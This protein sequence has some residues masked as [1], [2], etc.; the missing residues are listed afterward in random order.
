M[1]SRLE[2]RANN[3]RVESSNLSMAKLLLQNR[4]SN[5]CRKER[6]G[7]GHCKNARKTME[8]QIEL[9]KTVVELARLD[10][11][12]NITKAEI[13][14]RPEREGSVRKQHSSFATV[15]KRKPS[16]SSPSVNNKNIEH[17]N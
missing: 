4:S 7:V 14:R 1:L 8:T 6:Q 15:Q 9:T 13:L 12:A 10:H 17:L 11:R 3:A 2:H 5:R 16:S